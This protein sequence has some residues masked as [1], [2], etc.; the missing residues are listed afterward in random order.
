M[1]QL[2][3]D[4]SPSAFVWMHYLQVAFVSFDLDPVTFTLL[5]NLKWFLRYESLSSNFG[6]VTE[7]DR[8]KA[9][10]MSPP[11]VSTGGLK[12]NCDINR[13]PHSHFHLLHTRD[14][15]GVVKITTLRK[16]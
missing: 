10:H 6:L 1:K 3:I 4:M 7:T 16:F 9:M 8:R 15:I 11:C 5:V 2:D 14:Q 13:Q 12:N